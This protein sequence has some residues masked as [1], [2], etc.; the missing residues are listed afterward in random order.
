MSIKSHKTPNLD[1]ILESELLVHSLFTEGYQL[2]FEAS[3]YYWTWFVKLRHHSNGNTITIGANSFEYE[4]R[5]N[6]KIIKSS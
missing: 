6:G 4:V 5:K 3:T 2:V 1:P